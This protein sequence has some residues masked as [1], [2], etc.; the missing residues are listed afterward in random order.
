MHTRLHEGTLE[1]ENAQYYNVIIGKLL[2]CHVYYSSSHEC[3]CQSNLTLQ[4]V[5]NIQLV[6]YVVCCMHSV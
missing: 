2:Q 3:M 4:R 6:L 1:S 5:F